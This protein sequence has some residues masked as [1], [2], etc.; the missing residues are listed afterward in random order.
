MATL[1]VSSPPP[2][3]LPTTNV[4]LPSNGATIVSGTWLDA[5]AQSPIGIASVKFEVS[6]G[7]VSDQV[8]SAGYGTEFGYIGGWDSSDVPN[9]VYTLQSVATDTDGNSA[10]SPG[11]TVTVD[12]PALNTEVLVPSAGA[13]L[14][15]SAAVLDAA[16][17]GTSPITG[18]R[19]IVTGGS[20]TDHAVG[21][22]VLTLYGWIFQWN[23]TTVANGNY[24]LQSVATE[25]GGA[26][27][28]S[29]GT[30]ITVHN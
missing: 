27:A 24:T 14:S 30:A 17:A 1:A 20:L 28:M 22:P 23:T 21:S 6:G 2:P 25:T 26:T 5:F 3:P 10:T 19:F 18:V 8:I 7:S 11:I 9:G 15:G 29:T 13:T 12:N 16:A 4:V